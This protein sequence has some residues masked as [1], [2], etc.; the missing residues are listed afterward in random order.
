MK[1]RTIVIMLFALLVTSP[2]LAEND[3]T[4][5]YRQLQDSRS[6]KVQLNAPYSSYCVQ[7]R[8]DHESGLFSFEAPPFLIANID[9]RI[10]IGE[11]QDS[12]IF[13]M[14]LD[15]M[16]A[17]TV[18]NG[19]RHGRNFK[20][21]GNPSID[22]I[23]SGMAISLDYLDLI[24][25]SPVFNP[26][27]PYGFG[28][29]GGFGRFF[30][31]FLLSTQNEKLLASATEHYQVNW[32]QLG[33]GRHMVFSIIGA[34]GSANLG[35]L[36]EAAEGLVLKGTIFAQNAWDALLGGGTTV[37]W[38][39]NLRSLRMKIEVNHKLGGLG[40]K[41]KSLSDRD[42]PM[43]SLSVDTEFADSKNPRLKIGFSYGSDTY[44]TPVYGGESQRRALLYSIHASYGHYKL[45][46]RNAT[47]F[48]ID[49]GK[50]SKSTYVF[51]A[52]AFDSELSVEI[53]LFRPLDDK[54]YVADVELSLSTRRADLKVEGGRTYLQFN[55][56]YQIED[57]TLRFSIDQ[58]RFVTASLKLK[59]V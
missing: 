59:D 52:K 31:G 51:T 5:T 39:L 23:L 37:G 7:L 18:T 45:E 55:W 46:A 28:V 2:I 13:S 44:E 3:L 36:L 35:E 40:V 11:I 29:L 16:S 19:F 49:R 24:S 20:S 1:K 57:C 41:L 32:G 53:P 43:D 30:A 17:E 10:R 6:L 15:P 50:I 42:R 48:D 14:M 4:L 56:E 22:P 9:D 38:N 34:S 21:I 26:D 54:P 27:S 58:D 47:S 33:I 25:L 8:Q 12:G